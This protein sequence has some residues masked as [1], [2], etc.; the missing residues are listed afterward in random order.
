MRAPPLVSSVLFNI[1]SL[2]TTYS[3]FETSSYT[4]NL[5]TSW[6][7]GLF[8]G[9]IWLTLSR[10]KGCFQKKMGCQGKR[11]Q[12]GGRARGVYTPWDSP[13]VAWWERLPMREGLLMTFICNG[14]RPKGGVV[15]P[16]LL[17][18]SVVDAPWMASVCTV[19]P[20]LELFCFWLANR[21]GRNSQGRV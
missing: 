4:W 15:Q 14:S 21:F 2:K 5:C 12:T 6:L 20:F 17:L 13:V 16:N 18:S 10:T 1:Q 19:L 8:F 3:Q 11:F 7:F 9:A